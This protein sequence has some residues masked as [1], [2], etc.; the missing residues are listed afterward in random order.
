[1]HK[2]TLL[3]CC[4]YCLSLSHSH[5]SSYPYPYP[6][7]R[8]HYAAVV[9]DD[10]VCMCVCVCVYKK[11][12]FMS[13]VVVSIFLLLSLYTFISLS[14]ILSDFPS[15]LY[16]LFSLDLLGTKQWNLQVRGINI[17]EHCKKSYKLVVEG[18]HKDKNEA[19]V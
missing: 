4:C 10:C 1:M 19:D 13:L 16:S 7:Q 2:R 17:L 3:M 14:S 8:Y 9:V 5:S 6:H 15:M 12:E 18:C 11:G